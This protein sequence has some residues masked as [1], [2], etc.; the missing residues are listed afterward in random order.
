ML[1]IAAIANCPQGGAATASF[2]D[3]ATGHRRSLYTNQ[4]ADVLIEDQLR[5]PLDLANSF[6]G[7]RTPQTKQLSQC[8]SFAVHN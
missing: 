1:C 8:W 2:K 3:L 5:P 6:P 4:T 7:T